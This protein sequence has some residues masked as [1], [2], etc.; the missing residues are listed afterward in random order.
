[1]LK[2]EYPS[3]RSES[4]NVLFTATKLLSNTSIFDCLKLA[5]YKKM[6]VLSF[7]IVTPVYD[8]VAELSNTLSAA[9]PELQPEITPSSPTK[10]NF[11]TPPPGSTKAVA[12]L[13]KTIPVGSPPVA[14]EAEGIDTG[15][16]T[17]L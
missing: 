13:L 10:I 3:G 6:P 17:W 11:A 8:D 12:L 15:G 1:M 9:A 2:R 7:A 14:A 4:A 16:I 5:A